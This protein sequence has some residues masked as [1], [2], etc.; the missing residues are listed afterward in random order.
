MRHVIF[1]D[2]RDQRFEHRLLSD[3]DISIQRSQRFF[4]VKAQV[5]NA[6]LPVALG[7]C[8]KDW[9]ASAI[10]FRR[11]V[12]EHQCFLLKGSALMG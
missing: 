2:E 6:L 9:H 10:A 4:G 1:L 7:P 8:C 3:V 5:Q 11:S 12:D